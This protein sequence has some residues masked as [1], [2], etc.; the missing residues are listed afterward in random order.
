MEKILFDV[1]GWL[2]AVLYLLAYALVSLKKLDGQ[3]NLF[4]GM[5]IVAG[6]LLVLNSIFYRI[7]APVALNGIWALIGVFVI[8]KNV[9]NLKQ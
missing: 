7:W 2:G 3:S 9:R 6:V 5:N 1:G 4:Q 8:L